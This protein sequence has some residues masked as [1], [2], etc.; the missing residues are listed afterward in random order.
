MRRMMNQKNK[1]LRSIAIFLMAVVVIALPLSLGSRNAG[2]V[3]FYPEALA[4]LIERSIGNPDVLVGVVRVALESES[5]SKNKLDDTA[6]SQ[7]LLTAIN[8]ERARFSQLIIPE[9]Q[10]S[11]TIKQIVKDI[12]TWLDNPKEYPEIRVDLLPLKTHITAS[13]K[14]SMD[15]LFSVLPP[16]SNEQIGSLSAIPRPGA[17]PRC[18]IP[19]PYYGRF[20]SAVQKMVK[21]KVDDIPDE[22]DITAIMNPIQGMEKSSAC[23]QCHNHGLFKSD[24][25]LRKIGEGKQWLLSVR[26][27]MNNIWIA[28]FILFIVSF[29]LAT[30]GIKSR[31]ERVKWAGWPLMLSGAVS[32]L[33]AVYFLH[34]FGMPEIAGMPPLA[35]VVVKPLIA[36]LLSQ[37]GSALLLQ[38]ALLLLFGAGALLVAQRKGKTVKAPER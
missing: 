22:I 8:G 19:E 38:A 1:N 20:T 15:S 14:P 23:M 34:S 28:V 25:H 17:L 30:A 18:R 31:S 26:A 10:L 2:K 29:V 21:Q 5:L 6:M 16:C 33:L 4:G 13:L 36:D 32:L 35:L 27:W 9:K 12:F 37:V 3:L 7:L 11:Q 24:P